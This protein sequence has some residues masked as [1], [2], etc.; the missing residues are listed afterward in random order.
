MAST[1]AANQL[2][3]HSEELVGP[4]PAAVSGG[5]A[6][7]VGQNVAF[8]RRNAAA[9]EKAHFALGGVWDLPKVAA[10]THT[11]GATV[12]WDE[13]EEKATLVQSGNRRIG[14][15][16]EEAPAGAARGAYLS[17]PQANS[18]LRDDRD[19][20]LSK[21]H[22]RYDPVPLVRDTDGWSN[23]L[24]D[25]LANK[26]R[27]YIGGA[28]SGGAATI[29]VYTGDNARGPFGD[30]QTALGHGPV[31]SSDAVQTNVPFVWY[32]A[33]YPR[34]FIMIYAGANASG[35]YQIHLAT[36][37][38]G[39]NFQ[40][41]DP[42]GVPLSGPVLPAGET[43]AWDAGSCDIGGVIKVGDR[44]YLQYNTIGNTR[45]M[46]CAWSED[47]RNWTRDPSNPTFTGWSDYD[48]KDHDGTADEN[49]GHF[50][51][52]VVRWDKDDGTPRYVMLVPHYRANHTNTR[53]EC[54]VSSD[55][56]FHKADRTWVGTIFDPTAAGDGLTLEGLAIVS[57]S[58]DTP[59]IVTDT[60]ERNVR[61]SQLTGEDVLAL[62]SIYTGGGWNCAYLVHH[63]SLSGATLSSVCADL[64]VSAP[65]HKL[66]PAGS[67]SNTVGLWIPSAAGWRDLT[68]GA[69]H[70]YGGQV[71][72]DSSG[73]YFDAS[74]SQFARFTPA[75][76]TID[77]LNA[78]T[79]AFSVEARVSFHSHFTSGFR[80]I[81]YYGS[82]TGA[83]HFYFYVTGAA[84]PTYTLTLALSSGGSTKTVTQ[85][86]GSITLD[87]LY[88]LA[89]CVTGG[90]AYFFKDGT[91]LNSGGTAFDWTIDSTPTAYLYIGSYGATA[92]TYWD[93]YIDEVR[94]SK[95]GR[96][97]SSYTAAALSCVHAASGSIFLP[98]ADFGQPAIGSLE[99]SATAP[100]GTSVS[101]AGRIADD[102]DDGST[103][104]SDYTPC[105]R[106]VSRYQQY[107]LALATADSS[108]SPA[109]ESAVAAGI[110]LPGLV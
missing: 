18:V 70:L 88:R 101:D 57:S 1:T 32:E 39:V 47:L 90:K 14:I 108:V 93:G 16:A 85:A 103:T 65:R 26:W 8:A 41:L 51:A 80:V 5:D 21:A 15:V 38:D 58:C 40:R 48:D 7:T 74:L 9:S 98:V 72:I 105:W 107:A 30:R 99:V 2:R 42:W 97:T 37:A 76:G 83:H 63:K 27:L 33:I 50:C 13:S 12:Y 25:P 68:G 24:Y 67:D 46:G 84:G 60:I 22:W 31:G 100:S 75:T 61:T 96:W 109:V 44:Y 23:V 110:H 17:L 3:G 91:L 94:I 36:S 102:L 79:G 66:A 52:D 106:P 43:G 77:V 29:V 19:A 82:G 55:P 35:L 49:Q 59:R 6:R 45:K 62:V 69:T 87:Q 86:L 54:Y 92:G 95:V 104:M 56:R 10:E 89:V 71:R 81:F 78:V 20:L 34:P 4:A 28:C 11:L 64:P 73:A 53:I